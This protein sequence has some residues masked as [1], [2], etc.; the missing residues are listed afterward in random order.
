MIKRIILK[1][2]GLTLLNT[3]KEFN[4]DFDILT[5][6]RDDILE[7]SAILQE[8]PETEY[9]H[10]DFITI[11]KKF[12]QPNDTYFLEQWHHR[13]GI[14]GVDTPDA[15]DISLGSKSVKIAIVDDGVDLIHEDLRV[16]AHKNFST[17]DA[18]AGAEHGTACAGVAAAIGDNGKGKTGICPNCSIISAKL[19]SEDGAVYSSAISQAFR[20]SVIMGADVI[21]NSWGAER[22]IP[23]SEE[24]RSALSFATT[25][26]RKGKGSVVVFASGNDNRRLESYEVVALPYVLG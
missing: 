9:A 16:I 5:T 1:K 8:L 15:W 24:L 3:K 18:N 19:L 17:E 22:A 10:P 11:Y 25:S 12:Y 14:G 6:H 2:Y 23:V 4:E 7:L 26:G 13:N 20:W 21:S